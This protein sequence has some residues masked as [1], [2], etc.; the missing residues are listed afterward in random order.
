MSASARELDLVG[1][2]AW[3]SLELVLIDGWRLRFAGGVTKRANSVLP[4]GPEDRPELD[5]DTLVGRIQTV[6]R[7]YAKHRLPARFQM[8]PSSWPRELPDALARRGYVDSDETL[9]MT[10][11]LRQAPGVIPA[12][13]NW[14]IVEQPEA[15]QV[16]LDAWWAVGGRGGRSEIEIARAIL[17]RIAPP[18][19]FVE[20]YNEARIAGV[21]LGVL[22]APWI[23]VY[24]MATLPWA[25]RRGCARAV[26]RSLLA[27]A[28]TRGAGRAHLSVTEPNKPA[29][30]LYGAFGFKTRQ[31]YSYFT[32]NT[33]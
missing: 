9:V 5:E 31:R 29:Q 27:W 32:L 16:W 28:R 6:E 20:C 25:R 14:R 30:R 33:V 24:C 15:S 2:R 23:G 13:A 7:A 26:L 4:L 11:S 3:P 22:D 21:G 1:A 10:S 8:T 12:E 19:V 18:R 17:A